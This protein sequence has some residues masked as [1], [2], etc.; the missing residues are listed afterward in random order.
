MD[1]NVNSN[2]NTNTNSI[3][4]VADVVG[5]VMKEEDLSDIES[6]LPIFEGDLEN[7]NEQEVPVME[8]TDPDMRIPSPQIDLD[9]M[10]QLSQGVPVMHDDGVPD[11][12]LMHEDD[13]FEEMDA[14][15]NK[16]STNSSD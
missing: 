11:A 9:E 13:L 10:T 15:L 1:S 12:P 7:V 8:S 16:V 3:Q 14:L 2:S 4:S 5:D 6:H